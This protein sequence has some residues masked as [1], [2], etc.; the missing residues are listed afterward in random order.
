RLAWLLARETALRPAALYLENFDSLPGDDDK[1][2][3][4]T[5]S[6]LEAI[7][8]FCRLA[9]LAGE[10]AWR[11][12]AALLDP[13]SEDA[14]PAF[15]KLEFPPLDEQARKLVWET[16]LGRTAHLVDEMSIA[17]LAGKFR[18]SHGQIRD[19]VWSARDLARWRSPD[20][21]RI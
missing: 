16:E 21:G 5:R 12:T 4:Y 3:Q 2:Q 6:L 15:I 18:F 20:D 7:Q 10:R 19:A 13:M 14:L 11:F 1:S 17:E 8:T 9:F